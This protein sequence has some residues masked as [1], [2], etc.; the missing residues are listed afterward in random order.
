MSDLEANKKTCLNFFELAT[1]GQIDAARA[2]LHD[3]VEWW[4]V[5]DLPT[6]GTHKGPEAVMGLYGMLGQLLAPPIKLNFTAV[7]AEEDRVAIEM[8]SDCTFLDGRPYATD[9]HLLF[10]LKDGKIHRVKEYLDTKYVASVFP[11]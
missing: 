6:S 11:M 9:Y 1:T 7:T 3:E 10:R 2:L 5:G 4:I 8:N